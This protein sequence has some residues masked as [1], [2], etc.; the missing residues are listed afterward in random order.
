MPSN[1]QESLSEGKR[2]ANRFSD[3]CPLRG[4]PVTS[5]AFLSR[6]MHMLQWRGELDPNA[7]SWRQHVK[8]QLEGA[9]G[10]GIPRDHEEPL[11]P[12]GLLLHLSR[13]AFTD[14]LRWEVPQ[15]IILNRPHPHSDNTD[16][17]HREVPDELLVALARVMEKANWHTYYVVSSWPDRMAELLNDKLHFA[18]ELSHVCWGVQFDNE[19]LSKG[20]L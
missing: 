9:K 18:A 6:F 5:T 8:R 20:V 13:D 1:N 17:F 15:K 19:V 4:Y 11:H 16:L 2:I 3:W 10:D 7:F 12:T 14:P